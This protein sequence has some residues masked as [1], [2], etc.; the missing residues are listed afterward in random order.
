MFWD[1]HCHN[2]A[3]LLG[4][5]TIDN[6]H[7]RHSVTDTCFKDVLLETGYKSFGDTLYFVVGD[8]DDD[9]SLTMLVE[10]QLVPDQ[11][12]CI[13][14]FIAQQ[15]VYQTALA[16]LQNTYAPGISE[17]YEEHSL[18]GSVLGQSFKDNLEQ[19]EL[20]DLNVTTT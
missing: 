14:G 4:F 8:D 1:Y 20:A 15:P 16:G 9:S 6:L 7:L 12:W 2:T 5:A 17:W 19:I 13:T 3:K 10:E 11:M 18:C